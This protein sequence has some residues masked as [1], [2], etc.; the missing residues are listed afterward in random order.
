HRLAGTGNSDSH[1]ASTPEVGH[2]R[3]FVHIG[4]TDD[5]AAVTDAQVTAAV[6][7]MKVSISGGPFLTISTADA[8]IGG[9][10][11]AP[12][13]V[14]HLM[15]KVQAPAWMGALDRVDIWQG[16]TS[17]RGA[18]VV[19]S[20]SVTELNKTV[21]LN[22]AVDL[23]VTQD[24]WFLA[25]VRGSDVHALW[26]VVQE[27]VPAYAITNPIFVDADGNGRFDALR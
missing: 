14:V 1:T 6:Q 27:A 21:R 16:D 9:L 24:T 17:A 3:N 26:P 8:D 19:Q 23:T 7:A 12:G 10:A 2:P 13:G 22:T 25:T 5:P 20:I 4:T 11:R 15:I 18:H